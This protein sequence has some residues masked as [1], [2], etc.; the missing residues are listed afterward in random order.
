[1]LFLHP[2]FSNLFINQ[3]KYINPDK[4]DWFSCLYHPKNQLF[5]GHHQQ[6]NPLQ[7]KEKT[8]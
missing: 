8:S 4:T 5:K 1:M 6:E 7:E 3:K 2:R